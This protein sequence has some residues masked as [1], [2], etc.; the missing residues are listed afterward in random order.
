MAVHLA[1][2]YHVEGLVGVPHYPTWQV[3]PGYGAWT[4]T[5]QRNGVHL[6]RLL[7]HIP[8]R[9]GL[10]GRLS[11]ELTFAARL[12]LRR[13]SHRVDAVIAV[14]PPL[15]GS[16][17]A[18][19]LAWRARVPFGVVVQDL[20][21]EG[22]R[23]LGLGGRLAAAAARRVESAVLRRADGVVVVHAGFA[24]AVTQRL[25]VQPARV[26]T[27]PNW[28]HV[29]RGGGDRDAV[30]RRLGWS[31]RD[32]VLH[33]GNMGAKQGLEC[34]V[35]AAHVAQQAGS[36]LHFVLM[37]DGNQRRRLERLASGTANVEF[38][39]SVADEDYGD[40]LAAADLLLLNEKPGVSAMSMP[41]KLTSYL[42]VGRPVLGCCDP[43]GATADVLR[44]S[45]GGV[46]VPAG[47]APGLARAA[48]TLLD[49]DTAASR[50]ATAG[51]AWAREHLTAGPTLARYSDWVASLVRRPPH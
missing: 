15:F 30:R 9:H 2:S 27:I 6:T 41:S 16:A 5:E 23:E 29:R 11:H 26:T 8:S 4:A 13:S 34:V 49:D 14:S 28:T 36:G 48:R 33:A 44:R 32:V 51:M 19:V 3:F 24:A 42:A 37:G 45:G 12:L 7:H 18:R 31:G 1:E 10:V 25:R 22:T 20:Y 46:V 43:D 21:S 50:L 17:A 40:V 47:D 38:L 39:D 35:E